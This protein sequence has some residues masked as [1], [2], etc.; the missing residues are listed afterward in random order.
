MPHLFKEPTGEVSKD[1]VTHV[2]DELKGNK[3]LAT[4][5]TVIVLH[6]DYWGALGGTSTMRVVQV[7]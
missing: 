7:G 4:G 6:G 2:I 1:Q 5:D 3:Q